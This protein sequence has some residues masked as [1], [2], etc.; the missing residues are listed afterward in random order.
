MDRSFLK[1]NCQSM[2]EGCFSEHCIAIN[3]VKCS[4]HLL[5]AATHFQ[6][7][8]SEDEED[9]WLSHLSSNP[10]VK[11]LGANVYETFS[12]PPPAPAAAAESQG[13]SDWLASGATSVMASINEIPISLN[14]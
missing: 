2:P 13:W 14:K 9:V 3:T 12:Q 1:T 4:F 7:D 11:T 8:V 6:V 10:F 5:S